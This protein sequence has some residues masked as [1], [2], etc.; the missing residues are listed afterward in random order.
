[1]QYN[2]MRLVVG[3]FVITLFIVIGA[4][5]GFILDEKGA[6]DKR[7][8]FHFQSDTAEYLHIGMSLKL[9]GFYIGVIDDITLKDDGSVYITFSVTK[10]NR[11]WLSEGSVLMSIKPLIGSPYIEL[12]TSSGSPLLQENSSLMFMVSDD[13]NDLIHRLEPAI[14][15]ASN[16]LNNVDII[17]TY[18][19]SNDS[20]LK[21][22][23]KNLNKFSKKLADNDS[24]LTSVTGDKKATQN[25]ID[26]LHKTSIIMKDLKKITGDISKITASLDTKIVTPASSSMRE[27]ERILKDIK[28]KLDAVD[29]TVRAVGG[30]DKDLIELKEQI[31]VGVQKS[32][33]LLDKVDAFLSDKADKEVHLP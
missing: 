32:N 24:I 25:L 18:L 30:Y 9:S 13:V 6:F 19:A 20:E 12:Y 21:Q 16:I 15:K 10:K 29:G 28:S 5:L 23:L 27:I 1:M 14:K 8:N 26:S 17:T 7:Y 4:F 31:S 3:L 33:K 22:I 2:K 11:H